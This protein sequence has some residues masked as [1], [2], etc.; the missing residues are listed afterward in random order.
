MSSAKRTAH[1]V[2]ALV[3]NVID[4]TKGLQPWEL[5]Q[6][7]LGR[8]RRAAPPRYSEYAMFVER[9][10]GRTARYL[11]NVLIPS[12]QRVG[13]SWVPSA[14]RRVFF[15][16][17]TIQRR[18]DHLGSYDSFRAEHWFFI[19]GILTDS[20]MA[21]WNADYLARM[22]HRSFTIVQNLSGNQLTWTD[23]GT[24]RSATLGWARDQTRNGR[25][26]ARFLQ[27]IGGPVRYRA[28]GSGLRA[29][30]HSGGVRPRSGSETP[31]AS[32]PTA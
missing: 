3:S 13:P 6:S 28:G 30:D 5:P 23:N 25:P 27:V 11:T 19:N 24:P 21:G 9:D 17:T 29:R 15:H 20:G 1:E 12:L 14:L 4:A 8:L 26:R 31:P 10:V 16:E 18:P 7:V 32:I 22:F 2:G